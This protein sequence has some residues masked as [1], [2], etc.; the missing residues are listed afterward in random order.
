MIVA[1]VSAWSQC[2]FRTETRT[3]FFRT[4]FSM[5]SLVLTVKAAGF[6]YTMLGGVQAVTW[7]DVKQMAL[8]VVAITAIV[9]VLLVRI[10]VSPGA[11]LHIAGAIK[12]IDDIL[13][14][15]K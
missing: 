5:A 1:A 14:P 15:K 2:T 7:A 3:A 12:R 6:V 8:V 13:D 4:L 11:A 9:T 10:P